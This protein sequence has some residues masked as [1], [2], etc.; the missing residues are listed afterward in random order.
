MIKSFLIL[1]LIMPQL[2]AGSGGSVYLC[3]RNDG[4]FCCVDLGPG[5]CICCPENAGVPITTSDDTSCLENT[6]GCC[7]GCSV[8]QP[9]EQSDIANSIE[10]VSIFE[11][12]DP[13]GCTHILL[14]HEQADV[15]VGRVSVSSD[16]DQFVQMAAGSRAI[17]AMGGDIELCDNPGPRFTP[18]A[19]LSQ[20][21]AGLS[22]VQIRC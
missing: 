7:C 18:P 9:V 5:N 12:S 16:V 8:S 21:L 4:S 6:M 17:P 20:S 11:S 15:C 19:I 3:V 13:C 1:M 14:C 22:S 2:L 10:R